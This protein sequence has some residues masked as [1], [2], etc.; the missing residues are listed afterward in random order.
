MAAQKFTNFDKFFKCRLIRQLSQYNLTKL[1][2]M[3]LNTSTTRATLQK[4]LNK[5][6][7]Q[8]NTF[9]MLEI[10]HSTVTLNEPLVSL[11]S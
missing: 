3:K 11:R 4:K 6:F 5:H 2:R 8:P 1:F 10:H 7:D 9:F